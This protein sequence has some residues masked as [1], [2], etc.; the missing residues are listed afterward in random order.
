MFLYPTNRH[1]AAIPKQTTSTYM[2]KNDSPGSGDL[3]GA[4][5]RCAFLQTRLEPRAAQRTHKNFETKARNTHDLNALRNG[6]GWGLNYCAFFCTKRHDL[7]NKN[8]IRQFVVC[9]LLCSGFDHADR[10]WSN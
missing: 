5:G 7:E 1:V 6:G 8:A 9:D 2:Q 3:K 10:S 4:Q